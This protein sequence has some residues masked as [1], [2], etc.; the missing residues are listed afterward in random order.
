M[1][2]LEVPGVEIAR[3][4]EPGYKPLIYSDGDWLAA[5]MNGT[6]DSWRVP[7]QIEQHPQTDELFVLV[8]GRALLIVA[9]GGPEPVD[10]HQL[11]M[12]RNVLYNVKAGIWH[13]TPMTEDA[14]FVIIERKG[15]ECNGSNIVTLSDEQKAL[16]RL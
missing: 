13:A 3:F 7:E 14:R 15:T 11:E 10:F 4:D 6:Q 9:G 2:D 5:L 16:I 1:P 12:E 8:Q